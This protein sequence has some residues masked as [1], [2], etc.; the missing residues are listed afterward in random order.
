MNK[1]LEASRALGMTVMLCPSDVVDNYV[2]YPQRE[3]IFTLPKVTVPKVVDATCPPVPDA[4]RRRLRMRPRTVCGELRLGR[5]A[6][7]PDDWR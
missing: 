5:H 7:G 4:G 3:A 2:G 6:P 1:A